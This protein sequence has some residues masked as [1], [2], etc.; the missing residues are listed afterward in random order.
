MRACQIVGIL[1]VAH[2]I[3]FYPRTYIYIYIFIFIYL[4]VLLRAIEKHSAYYGRTLNYGK[5]VNLQKQSS[6]RFSPAVPRITL[7]P[8]CQTPLTIAEVSN[9]IGDC[10]AT[11]NRLKLFWNK[12]KASVKWKIQIFNAIIRSKLLYG[13]ECLQLSDAELSELN[14]FQK[15]RCENKRM[16]ACLTESRKSTVAL[17]SIRRYLA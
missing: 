7:E 8:C 1:S 5:C 14:A 11:C 4:Y 2:I 16:P 15:N 12:A 9:R 17:L 13:L 6:I 3:F 10:V